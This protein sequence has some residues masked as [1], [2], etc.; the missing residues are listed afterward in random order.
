VSAAVGF[1]QLVRPWIRKSLG[2]PRPYLPTLWAVLDRDLQVKPGRAKLLRV[3]LEAS[4]QGLVARPVGL[5]SSG[6]L[7]GLARAQGL[8]LVSG[9]L[10]GLAA[11]ERV[12]VQV[13]DP[14]F[15]DRELPACP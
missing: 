1:A 8:A 4:E 10:S 14:D 13:L 9:P 7:G 6:A 11:G 15:A 5:N 12:R 2:D 3:E